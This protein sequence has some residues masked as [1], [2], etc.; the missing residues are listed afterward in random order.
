MLAYLED[1]PTLGKPKNPRLESAWILIGVRLPKAMNCSNNRW[2][3][4]TR[5]NLLQCQSR[6]SPSRCR[7]SGAYHP[8]Y[9]SG[10]ESRPAWVAVESMSALFRRL[11][12]VILTLYQIA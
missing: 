7:A 6:S 11:F 3:C 2:S 9:D 10:R 12:I 8:P 4:L 1:S 5:W